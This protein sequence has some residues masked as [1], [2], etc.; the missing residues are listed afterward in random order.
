MV[1]IFNVCRLVDTLT[2]WTSS[3][4]TLLE[5]ECWMLMDFNMFLS[6]WTGFFATRC[7]LIITQYLYWWWKP[8]LNLHQTQD[9]YA[10]SDA[11]S[12]SSNFFPSHIVQPQT[13]CFFM[14]QDYPIQTSSNQGRYFLNIIYPISIRMNFNQFFKRTFPSLLA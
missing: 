8:F 14:L 6:R 1:R 3:L 13:T 7:C 10:L 5:I 11:M 2:S 9:P 4:S 12:E